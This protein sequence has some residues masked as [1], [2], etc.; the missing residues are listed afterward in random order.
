MAQLVVMYK[1]PN[2][3]RRNSNRRSAWDNPCDH[4]SRNWILTTVGSPTFRDAA[5]AIVACGF[6][7]VGPVSARPGVKRFARLVV[8]DIRRRKVDI[9][10]GGIK[11][12]D[13]RC[14]AV[15]RKS[16]LR[17]QFPIIRQERAD[18]APGCGEEKS[19]GGT[20][21]Q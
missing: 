19:V 21:A 16:E 20:E 8:A 12:L 13:H 2:D 1:T 6:L 7:F 17:A 4:L 10:A 3:E 11:L 9:E 18:E 15:T 5:C 14:I